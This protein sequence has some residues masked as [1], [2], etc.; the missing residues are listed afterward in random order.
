MSEEKFYTIKEIADKL[1][2]SKSAIQ[3]KLT[4]DFKKK[5]VINKIINGRSTQIVSEPCFLELKKKTRVKKTI[6]NENDNDDDVVE[7]L[8]QQLKKKDEQSE[9]L[10]I[11]LNQS[12]QLQLKQ[13]EK[14]KM[15]ETNAKKHWWQKFF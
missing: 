11:L 4:D 1:H 12:Q 2:V 10:Q 3:Q 8:K 15:L 14:I 6:Q 7:I 5:F 13:D 9:K